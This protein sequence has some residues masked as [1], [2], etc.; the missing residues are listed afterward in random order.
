MFLDLCNETFTAGRQDNCNL[1]FMN[2][3][4]PEKMLC[5]ISKIHFKIERD[6]KNL[7]SPVYIYDMGRNGTFVNGA[8]I[9]YNKKRILSNDDTISLVN[10]LYKGKLLVIQHLIY[11]SCVNIY[12]YFFSICFQRLGPQ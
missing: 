4:M 11:F 9:G 1:R 3:V 2:D 12:F 7:S 10:P 8:R 6:I 5:R